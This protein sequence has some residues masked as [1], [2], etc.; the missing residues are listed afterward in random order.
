M[1]AISEKQ[2]SNGH[3]KQSPKYIKIFGQYLSHFKDLNKI[4]LKKNPSIFRDYIKSIQIKVREIWWY[5]FIIN[6]GLFKLYFYMK[7]L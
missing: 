1:A 7:V 5:Y 6:F 2:P 3:N 4:D